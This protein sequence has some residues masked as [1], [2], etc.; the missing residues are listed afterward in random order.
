MPENH[1]HSRY[2]ATQSTY[3]GHRRDINDLDLKAYIDARIAAASSSGGGS[4]L[5]AE[6]TLTDAQIKALPTTPIE[7]IA[8]PGAGKMISVLFINWKI[9]VTAGIY[10]NLGNTWDL[11]YGTAS[12]GNTPPSSAYLEDNSNV[13]VSQMYPDVSEEPQNISVFNN[14]NLNLFYD[15]LGGGNLTGGN[16]AN[17]LKIIVY[18]VVVDL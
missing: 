4:Y 3:E 16:A 6:V 11:R 12:S 8:A 13:W 7:L 2:V 14:K 9:D 5:V 17:T 15:N 18:Y 10:T 1:E